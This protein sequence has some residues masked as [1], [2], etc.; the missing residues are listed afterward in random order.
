MGSLGTRLHSLKNEWVILDQ[1]FL[2]RW[3]VGGIGENDRWLV[4]C[5]S[6]PNCS[7]TEGKPTLQGVARGLLRVSEKGFFCKLLITMAVNETSG[8]VQGVWKTPC[9]PEHK[10]R[11]PGLSR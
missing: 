9:N 11:G 3:A 6:R 4:P 8:Q 5:G 7:G 1:R 10:S 2:F